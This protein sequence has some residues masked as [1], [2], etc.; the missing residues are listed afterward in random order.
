MPTYPFAKKYY[1][2]PVIKHKIESTVN[3]NDVM[4]P[5]K[6]N[7]VPVAGIKLC[8]SS[9]VPIEDYKSILQKY[10]G[11]HIL[12]F[13]FNETD[14]VELRDLLSKI[15][16]VGSVTALLISGV[17]L[18]TQ[19]NPS[20]QNAADIVFFLATSKKTH[21]AIQQQKVNIETVLTC[22]EHQCQDRLIPLYY[23]YE[24]REDRIEEVSQL[25]YSAIQNKGRFVA[26]VIGYYEKKTD[27]SR[28]QVLLR[29]WLSD[30]FSMSA[31]QLSTIC[32]QNS[33]RLVRQSQY[34]INFLD[35][36]K[37]RLSRWEMQNNSDVTL[38][39]I[40]DTLSKTDIQSLDF[41]AISR[42]HKLLF[43]KDFKKNTSINDNEESS[44]KS[45]K[46]NNNVEDLIA[47]SLIQTLKLDVADKNQTF[48]S[49][50]LDSISAMNF[51]TSLEKVLKK[52]I[53]PQ[54]LIDFP[55]ISSF[56]KYVEK[57]V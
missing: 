33:E 19:L 43:N 6:N 1:W 31:G 49:Y 46:S 54:W 45:V 3:T 40:K 41:E 36:I 44:E 38:Q 42:L 48:Q 10:T 20:L 27:I 51:V 53:S 23:L 37:Q 26:K 5:L 24:G 11:K 16:K 56:S 22:I 13:Y 9:I 47:E 55:T 28:F 35:E 57:Q 50:G 18:T 7:I 30:D 21:K 34:K 52:E 4:I 25:L 29:E 14:F 2:L 17:N 8:D 39:S 32:Y 15:I 12:I